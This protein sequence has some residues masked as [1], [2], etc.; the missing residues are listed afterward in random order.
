MFSYKATIID[1]GKHAHE[2]SRNGVSVLKNG[3]EIKNSLAVHAIGHP[4][5]TRDA[6]AKILYVEGALETRCEES[7]KRCHQ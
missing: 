1:I 6:V 7:S 5:M 4:S 2:E 3:I